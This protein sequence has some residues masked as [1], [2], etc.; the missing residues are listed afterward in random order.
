MVPPNPQLQ[1]NREEL[2]WAAGFFDGEGCTGLRSRGISVSV[3]QTDP[4]PL[5]R[6]QG[7]VLGLGVMSGP[8]IHKNKPAWSPRWTWAAQN[9]EDVQ[10]VVAM[11]WIF[12]SEPKREQALRVLET[13]AALPHHG[14]PI[15]KRGHSN[16]GHKPDGTGR[17]CKDCTRVQNNDRYHRLHPEARYIKKA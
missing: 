6:F 9:F 17:Y 5:L 3:N 7:A 13:Y 16:W 15:C 12:L 1:I 2:A 4:R 8:L 11:L 14:W 10:A